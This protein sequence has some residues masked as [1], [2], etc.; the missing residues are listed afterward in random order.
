[1]IPACA[2]MSGW[3]RS[4]GPCSAARAPAGVRPQ[5]SKPD[6]T[7]AE[8]LDH[9]LGLV[10]GAELVARVL[11]VRMHRPLRDREGLGD[12]ARGLAFG[13]KLHHPPLPTGQVA[14]AL[15]RQRLE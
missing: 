14:R 3:E 12:V 11:Q 2:G 10:A 4:E 7:V 15:R 8:R 13:R 6:L 1:W 9:R 5:S